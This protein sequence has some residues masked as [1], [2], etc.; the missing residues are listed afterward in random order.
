MEID[1]QL[2]LIPV[3]AG[4]IGYVTNWVAVKMLFYPVHFVGFRIP[5]LG[6]LNSYLPKRIR[7][8][9]GVAHGGLGWQG[10]IPSRAAKMG[11]IAVDKGIAK[12]GSPSEFYDRLEPD[13][14][15]AHIV[16]TSGDDIWELVVTIIEREHPQLWADLPPQMKEEVRK[17][18]DAH[19]PSIV[20]EITDDIGD[21]VDQL[22]DIKLMVIR[23]IEEQPHLANRIF[24]E[25]G[26]KEMQ[27]IVNSGFFFGLLLGLPQVPLFAVLEAWWIL[28]LGGIVVGYLTNAIALRVIFEPVRPK[29]VGP[30]TIQ[31]LFLRRQPEVAGVYSRIIAE[32]IV[33]LENIGKELMH[34]RRSDR[35]RK[36]ISDRMRPAIDRTLGIAKPAVR[37][38]F[39]TREYD[40]VQ[41][42]LAVGAI[43]Y[44]MKPF[45]DEEFN[46]SQSEA[47]YTL[48]EQRMQE[49]PP[50]DFSEMLRTAIVEDEWMLILL[51][52]VLGFLAGCLQ[53]AFVF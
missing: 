13:K 2:L 12:L 9:P 37:V 23:R 27:F 24:L 30:F 50:E 7:Q 19:L 16:A 49:L 42:A 40:A 41:E 4:A 29:K 17:R 36:L 34:G 31:G 15:A 11:S 44:T 48:L 35:T 39:G 3:I 45:A 8:I 5:G 28:P 14:I 38:A 18:L 53:I 21:N 20:K 46:K 25:V 10:I 1:L 47:I 26:E 51:G 32:D 33:N 6:L 22:L 43:D 52:A